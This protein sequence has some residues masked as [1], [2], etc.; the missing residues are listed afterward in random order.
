MFQ[1]PPSHSQVRPHIQTI[2]LNRPSQRFWLLV[3]S[4]L[5]PMRQE[6]HLPRERKKHS[7]IP[8]SSD[9]F[10]LGVDM[11]RSLRVPLPVCIG[12]DKSA[13]RKQLASWS[14]LPPTG[15]K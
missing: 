6:I 7:E 14:R 8:Q 11:R 3:T 5:C 13:C 12:P 15:A 10:G 4:E 2:S 1:A 9:C